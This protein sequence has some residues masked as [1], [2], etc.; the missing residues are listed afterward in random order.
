M[1]I[2]LH[3]LCFSHVELMSLTGV[4]A[5][6]VGQAG[7]T[8]HLCVTGDPAVAFTLSWISLLVQRI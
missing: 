6:A 4:V 1:G 2:P 7:L 8:L 5:R 3:L